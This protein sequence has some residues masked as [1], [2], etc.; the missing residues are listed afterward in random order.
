MSTRRSTVASGKRS[1]TKKRNLIA[2]DM[3]TNGLYRPKV[4]P[5]IKEYKRNQKHKGNGYGNCEF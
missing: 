1:K 4:E 3:H 2:L 5:S